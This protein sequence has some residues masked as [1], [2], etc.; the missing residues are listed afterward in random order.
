MASVLSVDSVAASL[1][2][3]LIASSSTGLGESDFLML[4]VTE[5]MNQDPLEPMDDREFIAQMAQ[6][7]TMNET[8]DFNEN[9]ATLQML[10][11]ASLVGRGVE[12]IGPLGE[13]V[14][15]I[16]TEVRFVNSQPRIVVNGET[17]VHLEDILRVA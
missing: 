1:G 12:A 8:A 11:S 14:L 2:S 7:Q 17:V 16:V 3:D 6:I 9:I 15:G 13:R 4:L 10:Q 5:L